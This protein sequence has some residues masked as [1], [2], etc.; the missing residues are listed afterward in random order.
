MES[1][2][3]A[4]HIGAEQFVMIPGREALPRKNEASHYILR[5]ETVETWFFLQRVTGK[6]MYKDWAWDFIQVS[7]HVSNFT[8][9]V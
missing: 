4:S 1:H 6:K 8:D 7:G 3:T 5:P 2:V 9:V